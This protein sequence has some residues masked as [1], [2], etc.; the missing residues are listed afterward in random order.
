[1]VRR[2]EVLLLAFVE[3]ADT[4]VDEYDVVEFLHRLA[5]RCVEL[6]G[7]AE[8]GIMLA[9]PD[10]SLHYLASSSERMRLVELLEL[11]DEEGPCLDAYRTAAPVICDSPQ[12][13][14]RRWPR[15]AS[16]AR[17]AG[18]Q[19]VAAI[20][21]RLRDEVIGALNLFSASPEPLSPSDQ[22]VAQ[23]LADI[24]TIGL[25]QERTIQSGRALSSQLESALESRIVI[26][27]AKGIIAEH[28]N[29]NVD[30]AFALLRVYSRNRNHLLSDTAREV[31]DG[32]LAPDTLTST[33]S[34]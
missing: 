34:G 12:D 14:E 21:M 13:A 17:D 33:T 3:F 23:A 5:V 15:F 24:A 9:S 11:Q 4:L 10:G 6:I 32:T 2:E 20:P 19:S 26:E 31:V 30:D 29:V 28:T 7:V 16:H 18:F 1:M 8:A 22:M 27:Q 25:L